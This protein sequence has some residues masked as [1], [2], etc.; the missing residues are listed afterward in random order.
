[1]SLIET[2]SDQHP[3]RVR[4]ER[5]GRRTDRQTPV[6]ENRMAAELAEM[7]ELQA[8]S[9]QLIQE[10]PT[11]LHDAI[12]D[13][14][15]RLLRSD[16]ATMQLYD[17]A[18][19][20]LTLLTS[21]GFDPEHIKLFD[22]V[23]RPAGTSC[24]AA[25]R[26]GARVVIPDIEVSECVVGTAQHEALRLCG[27]RAAQSTPLVSRTGAVIGMI[28][29]H[30]R[31]PHTPSERSLQLIDVLARQAADMIDRNSADE[32][33]QRLAA[34]VESSNDAII[35]KDLNGIIATWNK[36][37]ERIF[38]YTAEEIIGKS[39]LL[40][41]PEELQHEEPLILGR[42]RNGERIEHY[43]TVRRRKDGS[44]FD[45][46]LTV[47][48][49]RGA[50]GKIMGASKIA[51]DISHIKRTHTQRELLLREMEH[52][53]KNL[54]A[55][56]SGVVSLSVRSATT[57]K[58]LAQNVN[59]RLNALAQ[60]H[61]LTLTVPSLQKIDRS[62]MLH[63]LLR[64]IMAPFDGESDDGKP[65][66]AI[67]GADVPV[68][69]D[70]VANFALLLH[71]FATNAAKY[72]ALSVP[73]GTLDIISSQVGDKVLLEWRERGGPRIERA[74]DREGFGSVLARMAV[75]GQLGGS[76]ERDWQ[77]EGLCIRLT[78]DRARLSGKRVP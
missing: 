36:G 44:L 28:T 64:T 12:L 58:E 8:I 43:E 65:R 26:A 40:L 27:I 78:I 38:G 11:R 49:V 45:V 52:R 6:A 46:S 77:P 21:R 63:E 68:G 66:I 41:I 3:S 31:T 9:T 56:A 2:P 37:A 42:I 74:I 4:A 50:D 5:G 30:W 17:K 35:S 34:I 69:A 54:F 15:Q 57:P 23:P 14:A 16:M 72:G 55:L 29:T 32:T 33:A 24:G 51:R 19:D 25:L 60:A 53:I 76:I 18:Q 13:A 73:G 62:T 70:T 20:G 39:V 10:D 22:L 47:S 61:A 59:A 67:T 71:E 1:M 7:R 75:T 48:P